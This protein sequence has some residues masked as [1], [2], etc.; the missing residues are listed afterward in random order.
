MTEEIVKLYQEYLE[1]S[2]KE[3][4]DS[5]VEELRNQMETEYGDEAHRL[6][7]IQSREAYTIVRNQKM[8]EVMKQLDPPDV[9]LTEEEKDQKRDLT[10]IKENKSNPVSQPKT[11]RPNTKDLLALAIQHRETL[12]IHVPNV[13]AKLIEAERRLKNPQGCAGCTR[14]RLIRS[15]SSS[16]YRAVKLKTIKV[17]E[18]LDITDEKLRPLFEP[19]T[20][21]GT[22]KDEQGR[23]HRESCKECVIKHLCQSLVLTD[24]ILQGYN[25]HIDLALIHLNNA[26]EKAQPEDA[27]KMRQ[28]ME[29][30]RGAMEIVENPDKCKHYLLA[31]QKMIGQATG[32]RKHRWRLIGQLGEAADECVLKNP[33]LADLIR[34]ERIK[35]MDD[36]EYKPDIELLLNV[37]SSMSEGDNKN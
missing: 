19:H 16:L 33:M 32:L 11:T 2:N 14:N 10:E 31:A 13:N 4:F 6:W 3:K 24:E 15:I 7:R 18:I 21:Q 8:Q 25:N 5:K 12:A 34:T 22:I 35:V 1:D 29:E 37:A 9:F 28:A 36:P 26:V 27:F 17:D 23:L 20:T 30:L